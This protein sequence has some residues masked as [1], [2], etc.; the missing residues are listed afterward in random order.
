MLGVLKS[1]VD[2]PYDQMRRNRLVEPRT[3]A[4]SISP[5]RPATQR[6]SR[7]QSVARSTK[8]RKNCTD[9][10][11]SRS[12]WFDK[13]PN[14]TNYED[15][16]HKLRPAFTGTSADDWQEDNTL[17]NH[18]RIHSVGGT[19]ATWSARL[20]KK[21]KD[22][23]KSWINGGQEVSEVRKLNADD[24]KESETSFMADCRRSIL[25]CDVNPYLLLKKQK[26]EDDLSDDLSDNALEQDD[27]ATRSIL[28]DPSK[29]KSIE[30]IPNRSAVAAIGGQRIRVFNEPREISD[31]DDGPIPPVT[32]IPLPKIS[33][34][35]PP[36]RLKEARQT[37][38]SILKRGKMIESKRK[39]VLF[40]VDNVIFAP[41]KPS[42]TTRLPWNNRIAS[43]NT[44][45]SVIKETQRENNDP[46]E[47]TPIV[48][49]EQQE[50][51]NFITIPNIKEPKVDRVRHKEPR[52][53]PEIKIASPVPD[54]IKIDKFFPSR[55][56]N[57]SVATNKAECTRENGVSRALRENLLSPSRIDVSRK[58]ERLSSE[59]GRISEEKT[60]RREDA[61][62]LEIEIEE[63]K[64]R[65]P[66][67]AVDE[68]D[69]ILK[70]EGKGNY[71]RIFNNN[72]FYIIFF[73]ERI[74]P[75]I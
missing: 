22:T 2:D 64:D 16:T 21:S 12:E 72:Y 14:V 46:I 3:R 67:I 26:D 37:L 65:L 56:V 28:F 5:H 6:D 20:S 58:E 1:P 61:T 74:N 52:I 17:E 19:S 54:R 68:K 29:V 13:E 40:N 60:I 73:Y 69:L 43:R 18:L 38:K 27:V 63:L 35:R 24:W 70:S 66:C 49:Q 41:E 50:K 9:S 75:R 42:E 34:K 7:S 23:K 59:E 53:V 57:R 55:K 33:P 48:P 30:R 62:E 32:R 47:E 45:S 10:T 39:N 15:V 44:N 71:R 25:E 36:R 8:E 31:D 51:H 4:R 11:L